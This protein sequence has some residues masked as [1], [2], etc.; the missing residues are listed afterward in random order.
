ML[1]FELFI[2]K[3]VGFDDEEFV[4]NLWLCFVKLCVVCC[5]DVFV[6]VVDGV[7]IGMFML[8]G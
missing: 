1:V 5:M 4:I 7:K 3:V 2:C 6:G 8:G